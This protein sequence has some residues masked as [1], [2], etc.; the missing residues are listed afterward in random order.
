MACG[1]R[2]HKHNI[3]TTQLP[4]TAFLSFFL[5]FKQTFP[6]SVQSPECSSAL[7]GLTC[8]HSN[9]PHTSFFSPVRSCWTCSWFGTGPRTWRITVSRPPNTWGWIRPL[10]WLCWR[11]EWLQS[12]HLQGDASIVCEQHH[13]L[14][15]GPATSPLLFT[16]LAPSLGFLR[17]CF[18]ASAARLHVESTSKEL[19]RKVYISSVHLRVCT[20]LHI[21]CI[22]FLLWL[23][24]CGADCCFGL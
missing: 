7:F 22:D 23:C 18:H 17:S 24:L 19:H 10:P 2:S 13:Q 14:A 1:I 5:S 12:D 6:I 8:A 21:R 9:Q 3:L 15:R 4:N 11:S 20:P 16:S